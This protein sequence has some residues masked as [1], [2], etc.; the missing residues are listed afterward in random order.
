MGGRHGATDYREVVIRSDIDV[1]GVYSPDHLH[2]EQVT[3]ALAAGKHIVR[4]K[5]TVTSV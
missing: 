1:V 4:T 3:A 2:T 5:P